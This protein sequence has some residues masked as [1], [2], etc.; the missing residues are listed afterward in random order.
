ME[1]YSDTNCYKICQKI[2][3]YESIDIIKISQIEPNFRYVD[4]PPWQNYRYH[5]NRR[6]SQDNPK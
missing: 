5:K 4:E 1:V 2:K 3:Y 6:P